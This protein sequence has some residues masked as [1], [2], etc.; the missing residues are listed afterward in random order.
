MARTSFNTTK[1]CGLK[2]TKPMNRIG[3]KGKMWIQTRKQ[4]ITQNPA[5]WQCYI[6][7]KHL[8]KETLTLDH[9]LS[10]GRHPELRY[11][12]DNLAPCCYQCNFDKGSK[13]YGKDGKEIVR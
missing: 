4:W 13:D 2:T 7:H 5:P 1:S 3:S 10:R 8:D 9:M 12:W 11:D 6:C